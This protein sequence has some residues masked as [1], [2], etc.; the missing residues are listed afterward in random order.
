MKKSLKM[1]VMT[2]AMLGG[3]SVC[4]AAGQIQGSLDIQ[5]TIGEGCAV[6]NGSS[7]PAGV[8]SFGKIDFGTQSSLTTSSIDAQSTSTTTGE[9]Q[10]NCTTGVP[11]R[12]TLGPGRNAAGDKRN[13]KHATAVNL[14][15]YD[16]YQDAARVRPWNESAPLTGT[17]TG[18][19]VSLTVYGRV[20]KAATTPPA[21]Q[22]N[23]TVLVTIA[24]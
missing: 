23:D 17:G 4:L 2:I 21:G 18:A 1:M 16:L 19:A 9:I 10:L 7:S 24:W 22:Y 5:L 13:M 11:Y 15:T 8:N 6:M 20:L 3:S 12:V 14:I